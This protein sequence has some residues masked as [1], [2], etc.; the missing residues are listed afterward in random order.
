MHNDV[1]QGL[2]SCIFSTD[3]R[4]TETFLS[5]SRIGLRHRQCQHR[6]VGRRDRRRIRRRKG[7]RR[8]PRIRLRRLESATCAAR[9]TPSTIRAHCRSRRASSSRSEESTCRWTRSP[10][11]VSAKWERSPRSCCTT[12]VSTSSGFDSRAPHEPLPFAV[13]TADLESEDG[14]GARDAGIRCRALL[15]AVSDQQADRRGGARPGHP[16]LRPDRGRADDAGHHRAQQD[17]RRADGAAMRAGAR[18]RRHRRR[19]AGRG[20]EGAA[21]CGCASARCRRIRPA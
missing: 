9:P 5:A 18:L 20:F 2:S 7:D 8:R 21:R 11:S 13:R 1:P 15:P 14:R 19:R 4:E 3:L 16:L 10:F 17:A 12:A 6:S